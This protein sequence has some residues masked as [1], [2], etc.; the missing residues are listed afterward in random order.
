MHAS[1]KAAYP[2]FDI[3]EGTYGGLDCF[4]FD[5]RAKLTIGKYC[6]LGPQVAILLGGD[7]PMGAATT[8]PFDVIFPGKA[9]ARPIPQRDVVIGND[10]WIGQSATILAGVTI[11]DGAVIA[12]RAL[13]NRDVEPYSVVG[14]V[15]ARRLKW[16]LPFW[17]I[18]QLQ[19][20]AW[21][22]WPKAR[23]EASVKLLTS[24]DVEAFIN[25][26]RDG[27]I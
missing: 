14:G 27:E 23:I 16:R 26:V 8:Y 18:K 1:L 6:S 25:A 15:P 2:G 5:P 13:V 21:W 22:N 19:A 11:G 20:I 10:V 24:P 17:Q 7:H 4:Q 12:A 3:G 9:V